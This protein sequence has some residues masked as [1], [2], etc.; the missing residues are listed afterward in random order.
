MKEVCDPLQFF[1]SLIQNI[2]WINVEYTYDVIL[3]L[4]GKE[5]LTYAAS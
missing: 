3:V 2:Y 4:K 5:I 1:G